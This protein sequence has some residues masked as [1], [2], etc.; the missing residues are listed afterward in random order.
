VGLANTTGNCFASV[1]AA[2]FVRPVN[3]TKQTMEVPAYTKVTL[4]PQIKKKRD[5]ANI[6]SQLA[7]S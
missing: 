7:N 2:A 4:P 5:W 3:Q 6:K 1:V